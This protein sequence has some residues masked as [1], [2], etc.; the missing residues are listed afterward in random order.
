M[1]GW[2]AKKNTAFTVTFPIYDADGDLVSGAAA[3]DSE[4]SKD[5]GTFTD[6]TNEAGEIATS[7][8]VY[9]LALTNTEMNADIVATITKTSTTGAK[10]A[11]NVMYTTT[12]QIDDLAFPTSSG[13]SID[14]TATG[15]V[16]IDWANVENPTTTVGLSGTTVKT[17]TDVE[18]DTS[19][20]QSRLPSA[21]VS[22]RMSS[23]AVAISGSTTAADNV[24]ANI[25]NLD[26]AVTSRAPESGG[27][28][29][30][31]KGK[32][33]NLPASPAAVGSA[34]TLEDSAISA[35]KVAADALHAIA[36]DILSRD[37][38]NVEATAAVHTLCTAVLKAV[39]RIRDNA[40]TLEVYRTN[41]T[42]VHMEQTITTDASNEP[43][44]ELTAGTAP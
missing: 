39:S 25:G 27:N 33:D 23:D 8:G 21:L 26:A 9:A 5:G 43:I 31:I 38:D 11:V 34:M 32:T 6:C 14:V 15:G 42:T 13:R 37:V 17:A 36:D 4:V 3:L 41:G 35:A 44:D 28:V 16:G 12:R 7:S 18:A 40:G 20:I 24:E 30:A 1:A 2:P 19:D 10:T 22:G 29:A